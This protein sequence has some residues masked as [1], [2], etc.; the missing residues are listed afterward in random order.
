[1][2]DD[3]YL[4]CQDCGTAIRRLTP[5]EEQVL[6]RHPENFIIWCHQCR[7]ARMGDDR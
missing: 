1:M 4:E 7:P 6:A 5:A 3:R 2:S